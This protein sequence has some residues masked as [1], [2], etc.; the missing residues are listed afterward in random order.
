MNLQVEDV[1]EF[2]KELCT[3]R[4]RVLGTFEMDVDGYFYFWRNEKLTGCDPS[5]VL[6]GIADKLDEVNK[7]W[8][9]RL[10]SIFSPTKN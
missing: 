9:E 4:G 5:Y 8:N 6:R 3:E 2:I 7:E 10:I 1:N